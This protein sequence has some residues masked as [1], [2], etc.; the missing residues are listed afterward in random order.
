MQ[1][2]TQKLTLYVHLTSHVLNF[3]DN[4]SLKFRT[5]KMLEF[6]FASFFEYLA[7]CFFN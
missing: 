1:L 6:I 5:D 7:A 3:D 4:K 2:N